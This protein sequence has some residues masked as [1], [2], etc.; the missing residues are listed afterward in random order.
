MSGIGTTSAGSDGPDDGRSQRDR[1]SAPD[2]RSPTPDSRRRWSSLTEAQLLAQCEVDTYRA[3]GPGG[4]KR[5]KTSS[6]VRL[7]HT[8]TG[9]IVIA[10]ESRSQHENK[11]KALTR[12]WHALFLDLR[13][14]LPP[15][16]RTPETIAAHP[17]Y[18]DARDHSGRLHMNAKNP[19]FW[20]AVGVVLDVLHAVE[21]RVSDAAE[22][23]GVSTGN[24]ID[25]L[26]TDP[27]VWQEANRLR[28]VFGQKPLR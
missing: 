5:N 4:Q 21:A 1:L 12:L 15:E 9:I 26:Q 11:A 19:R 24:L 25:F 13:D 7:R 18:R 22:L 10:E 17:D 8:P 2:P 6:A 27:K 28:T 14:H 20:P 16:A 3:S 23:L